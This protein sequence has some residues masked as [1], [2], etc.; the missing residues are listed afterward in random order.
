[1]G[2]HAEEHWF[3]PI[4]ESDESEARRKPLFWL[5]TNKNSPYSKT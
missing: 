3:E 1:M 5:E 4:S 2:Y